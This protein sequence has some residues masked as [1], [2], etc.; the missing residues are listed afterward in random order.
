MYTKKIEELIASNTRLAELLGKKTEPEK[1]YNVLLWVFA[2]IGVIT[3]VAAI[4][5]GVYRYMNP[6]YFDD[7]DFDDFDEDDFEED[8]DEEEEVVEEVIEEAANEATEE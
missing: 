7:I 6:E 1:K 2:I 3:A 4:A 8:F 5:Y